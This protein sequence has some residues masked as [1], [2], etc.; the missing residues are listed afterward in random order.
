MFIGC[1]LAHCN[2]CSSILTGAVFHN[3][4]LTCTNFF[5]ADLCGS[6]FRES[7]LSFADFSSA[8]LTQ[9]LFTS[10]VKADLVTFNGVIDGFIPNLKFD[11]SSILRVPENSTDLKSKHGFAMTLD[12]F[13]SMMCG[14]DAE[15]EAILV[16]I[17]F[18]I[19]KI[20]GE[21]T[22]SDWARISIDLEKV[23]T[24]L[25]TKSDDDR[26]CI[27]NTN[28]GVI[29]KGIG[30]LALISRVAWSELAH[31]AI[32]AELTK[33]YTGHFDFAHSDF[34]TVGA[35][36]GVTPVELRGLDL[37]EHVKADV[38]FGLS[39][40]NRVGTV[41]D[42]EN[43]IGHADLHTIEASATAEVSV[44]GQ[45]VN[46]TAKIAGTLRGRYT[47]WN[48]A[49]HYVLDKFNELIAT[50]SW[51]KRKF[52][53]FPD[54]SSYKKYLNRSTTLDPECCNT[55]SNSDMTDFHALIKKYDDE[56]EDIAEFFSYFHNALR[57][58]ESLEDRRKANVKLASSTA[59]KVDDPFKAQMTISSGKAAAGI[60]NV[61]GLEG[62]GD[63]INSKT[64]IGC[65]YVYQK[66]S[67]EFTRFKSP[68]AKL[69]ELYQDFRKNQN[70]ETLEQI[71]AIHLT[72]EGASESLCSKLEILFK[73]EF[74]SKMLPQARFDFLKKDFAE[75]TRFQKLSGRDPRAKASI[76][77]FHK[78]YGVK[79]KEQFLAW[80]ITL[81]GYIY[82]AALQDIQ[83]AQLEDDQFINELAIVSDCCKGFEDSL[84]SCTFSA[85]ERVKVKQLCFS[86][87][88]AHFY[89]KDHK[90]TFLVGVPVSTEYGP[91]Q[92]HSVAVS[93]V[94]RERK[95]HHELRSGWTYDISVAGTVGLSPEALKVIADGLQK[96]GVPES[97]T[98]QLQTEQGPVLSSDF[99]WGRTLT[100]R[101]YK[102]EFFSEL[103]Y[104]WLF[105]KKIN[106]TERTFGTI[107]PSI[108][109]APGVNAVKEM[110]ALFRLYSTH[111]D[112]LKKISPVYKEKGLD[113]PGMKHRNVIK[114]RG[115]YEQIPPESS[116][117]DEYYVGG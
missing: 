13:V 62:S 80:L 114:R 19:N 45:G 26:L 60:G 115:E 5:G 44:F 85:E 91:D 22:I 61:S 101:F 96:R 41:V 20:Q 29:R 16:R 95:H 32:T 112:S 38:S 59:K 77:A 50:Q 111:V 83:G 100:M 97:I 57:T 36:A 86:K 113:L 103:G 53:D 56:K 42:D 35:S 3:C 117:V 70:K 49:E 93:V 94:R 75:Y 69:A 82:S 65:E 8:D 54:N 84:L 78:L 99:S 21:P 55:N 30:H 102:P 87:E 89:T 108:P 110:E 47:E 109:V 76:D 81:N 4:D 66:T 74:P 7:T 73:N 63:F 79:S 51:I 48:C 27:K 106:N 23:A 11:P 28:L 14:Y 98:K 67:L 72:L 105:V 43:Y 52:Y 10:L 68:V 37:G 64:L 15:I 33:Y 104:R 58:P 25:N 6:Y 39:Y 2:F 17:L 92:T 90:F 31:T 1:D 34:R 46:A 24:L 9:S 116:A 12:S 71:E 107:S 40:G 18:D 88:D